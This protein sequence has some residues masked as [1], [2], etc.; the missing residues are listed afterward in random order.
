MEK[1]K[2]TPTL[3]RCVPAQQPVPAPSTS[4]RDPATAR[5]LTADFLYLRSQSLQSPSPNVAFRVLRN[6]IPSPG[7]MA[8]QHG[9]LIWTCGVSALR[10]DLVFGS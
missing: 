10:D 3:R 8:L 7:Y 6:N 9:R 1:K 5:R 2:L 4:A